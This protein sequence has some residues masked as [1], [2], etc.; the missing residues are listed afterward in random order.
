VQP[1]AMDCATA[2][3][4][5]ARSGSLPEGRKRLRHVPV[6]GYCLMSNHVHLFVIPA[7]A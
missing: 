2:A 3:L 7:D 4:T 6:A 1:L 5:P